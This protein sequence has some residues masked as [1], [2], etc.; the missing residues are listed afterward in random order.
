[1]DITIV[2]IIITFKNHPSSHG[3]GLCVKLQQAFCVLYI[4]SCSEK[5][6]EVG[7]FLKQRAATF[8]FN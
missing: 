3:L 4:N 1:M 2:T 8:F 5:N 7:H 6:P